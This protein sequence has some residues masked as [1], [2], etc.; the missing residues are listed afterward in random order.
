[1]SVYGELADKGAEKIGNA[2]TTLFIVILV[3][4]VAFLGSLATI[5]YLIFFQ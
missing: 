3:L 2:F 1:M 4:G 5:A